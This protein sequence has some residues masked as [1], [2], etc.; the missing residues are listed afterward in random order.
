MFAFTDIEP[1]IVECMRDAA[2]I[3]GILAES[4]AIHISSIDS[5]STGAAAIDIGV[6]A[7]QDLRGH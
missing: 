2:S 3:L 5:V 1:D 6:D 7:R 4:L